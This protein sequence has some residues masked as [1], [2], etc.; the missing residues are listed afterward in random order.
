MKQLSSN[1]CFHG[2]VIKYQHTSQVLGCDMKFNVFLPTTAT[3]EQKV[4][5][6]FFLSG[7]TCTEDN[8]F[9]KSGAF[10]K[11]SQLGIAIVAP[12]TSPR[13]LNIPGD[14]DSWD[15]GV[16]AGFYVNAT[17]E[18]WGKN[19][20]M[21]DYITVEL[22]N[23]IFEHLPLD[24]TRISVFGHSMGGHGALIV[25]LKNPGKY[26]SVSAF[27]PI[28]NPINCPWGQKAFSGYLGD[29]ASKWK[30]YDATELMKNHVGEP[31]NILIDQGDADDFYLKKQLLPEAFQE[32]CKLKALPLNLRFQAGYDHSYYF[33]ST[34]V[35][36]HIEFHAKFLSVL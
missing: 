13:G 29:D 16:G 36:E 12:D 35:S 28:C 1:K 4:P 21:Y 5:V 31:L 3:N 26:K 25:A 15:F 7:L 6:L 22:H 11:A 33:I 8:F 27:S 24:P 20:K 17:T 19:Y 30:E 32:A 23:L 34:F 14:S 2:H 9:H 18:K 10:H